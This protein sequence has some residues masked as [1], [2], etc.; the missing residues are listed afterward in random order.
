MDLLNGFYLIL[1]IDLFHASSH[2][3]IFERL[4]TESRTIYNQFQTDL[5]NIHYK[6][7]CSKHH[8]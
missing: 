3:A 7:I 2:P 6:I 4:K 5:A 1:T 8:Y